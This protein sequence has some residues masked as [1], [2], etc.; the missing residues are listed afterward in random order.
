LLRDELARIREAGWASSFEETNLGVWGLAVPILGASGSIVCA[1]GIAGPSARLA[2][3]RI[4]DLIHRI[5]EGAEEIA[6]ALGD[7][8]PPTGP[9][10]TITKTPST[11]RRG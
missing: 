2:Q 8:V 5:H 3:E 1:I 6:Q 9:R 7:H 4:S 10:V 11:R